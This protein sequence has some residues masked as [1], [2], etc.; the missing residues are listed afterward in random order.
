MWNIE[1]IL[2]IIY[3]WRYDLLKK[4]SMALSK[5]NISF[6]VKEKNIIYLN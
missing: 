1:P 3:A 4:I 2:Y 6:F 5:T